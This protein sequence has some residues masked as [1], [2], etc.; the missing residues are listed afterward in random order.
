MKI[1]THRKSSL[2][3]KDKLKVNQ[4]ALFI[5]KRDGLITPAALVA[6]AKKKTSVIHHLFE[7]DLKK[8]AEAHWLERAGFLI[9][10]VY[11]QVDDSGPEVRRFVNVKCPMDDHDPDV[12]NQ[13]YMS[14]EKTTH[15]LPLREQ[16]LA[17]AK[18]QLQ[19][20]KEKFG[21]YQEFYEVAKAID[22]VL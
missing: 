1:I 11:V 16:V 9:R 22:K 21:H 7:W 15:N 3:A 6:E 10:Q 20:W 5:E 19:I 8:A 12:I 13:G 17:Y 18:R 14:I 2:S 4:V